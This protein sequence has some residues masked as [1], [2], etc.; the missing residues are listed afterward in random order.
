MK[1]YLMNGSYGWV[2]V[3][4]TTW[5]NPPDHMLTNKAAVGQDGFV[6]INVANIS[7][8]DLHDLMNLLSR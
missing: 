2:E 7:Q 4:K 6:W 8:M 5:E 3:T 1:Y